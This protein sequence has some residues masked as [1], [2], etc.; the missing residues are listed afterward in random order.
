MFTR[1]PRFPLAPRTALVFNPDGQRLGI[2]IG[3]PG[4]GGSQAW[5]SNNLAIYMPWT[6]PFDATIATLMFHCTAG[7]SAGRNYDIGIYDYESLAKLSSSGS[8]LCAANLN[9]WT[10]NQAVEGGQRYYIAL[11]MTTTSLSVFGYNPGDASATRVMLRLLGWAEEASAVPLPST[12]TPAQT[13]FAK[14]PFVTV[15]LVEG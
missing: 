7:N 4:A 10:A 3:T 6:A 12:A 13:S 11:S 8:T 15:T 9:T 1:P 2:A 14:I 5:P